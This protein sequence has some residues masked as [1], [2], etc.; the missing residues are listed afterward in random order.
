MPGL[1]ME[2]RQDDIGYVKSEVGSGRVY[3]KPTIARCAR[4]D[5]PME[6][7]EKYNGGRYC[8]QCS[9]CHGCR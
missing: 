1:G 5:F 9:G 6:I 3:E 2:R 7:M 4:M 8:V